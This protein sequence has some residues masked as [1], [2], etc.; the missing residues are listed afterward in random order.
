[1]SSLLTMKS[2]SA[3][4]AEKLLC[5]HQQVVVW[6]SRVRTSASV[7]QMFREVRIRNQGGGLPSVAIGSLYLIPEMW[8]QYQPPFGSHGACMT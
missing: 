3:V 7:D 1:M 5:A 4:L 8:S 6:C 2:N